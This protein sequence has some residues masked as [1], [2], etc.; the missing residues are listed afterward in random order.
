M[1]VLFINNDGGGYADYVEVAEGITVEQ[2]FAETNARPQRRR[3][4]DPRQSSARGPRLRPARGRPRDHDAH[5]DRRG[6]KSLTIFAVARGVCP[7]L[8]ERPRQT[9]LFYFART[10]NHV[11]LP[12]KESDHGTVQSRTI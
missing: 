6:P 3:L 10:P 8:F 7:G 4:P 5:E 11:L 9:P 1:R 12:H 2:F